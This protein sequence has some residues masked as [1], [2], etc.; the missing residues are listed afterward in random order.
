MII[1]CILKLF[2]SNVLKISRENILYLV[3][4][5]ISRFLGVIVKT[6]KNE[7]S[8]V[9]SKHNVTLQLQRKYIVLQRCFNNNCHFFQWSNS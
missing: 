2:L 8:A 7:R 1:L 4:K 5:K 9:E 3:F 6:I